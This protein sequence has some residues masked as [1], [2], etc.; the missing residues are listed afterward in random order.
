LYL[1]TWYGTELAF[2]YHTLSPDVFYGCFL[3]IRNLNFSTQKCFFMKATQIKMA[4]LGIAVAGL[5][6][7]SNILTG[8]IR[9]KVSPPTG[10]LRAWAESDSDT[11]HATID[12]GVFEFGKAKPGIYKIVI[13]AKP[14]YKNATK[15]GVAV[16][17]GE[18][19]DIGEI[20]LEK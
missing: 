5:L 1:P 15:E 3:K 4:A 9:G 18:S 2:F 16:A 12:N 20:M 19:T 8:S 7:F 14:P 10:A 17:D 13:E 11:L 6:A